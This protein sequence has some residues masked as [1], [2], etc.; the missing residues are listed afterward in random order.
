M[1]RALLRTRKNYRMSPREPRA[2]VIVAVRVKPGAS[3]PRVGGRHDG[4]LGPAVVLAVQERAVDGQATEAARRALADALGVSKADVSLRSGAAA[5]DKLFTVH[6][7]PS[8]VDERLR[9][10]LAPT[11]DAP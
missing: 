6:N 11:G 4:P 10:L 8:D 1:R 9:R 3:H 7:P 5:R 2:F